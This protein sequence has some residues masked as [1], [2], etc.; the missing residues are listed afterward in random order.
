MKVG[1]YSRPENKLCDL[2]KKKKVKLVFVYQLIW[3][4]DVLTNTLTVFQDN[5]I[6]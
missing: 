1:Y 5:R 2:E 4:R 6:Y 3:Q